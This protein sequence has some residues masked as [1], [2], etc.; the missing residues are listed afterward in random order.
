VHPGQD[1]FFLMVTKDQLLV[2]LKE[3]RKTW[4]SGELL[5][6]EL[7]V[8]RSAVWKHIRKL[9]EEG[10]VIESSPKKGYLLRRD[11]D[12]LL[13]NE[14]RQGL[15]TEVFGK[16]GIEYFKEID[17]TNTKAKDLAQRGAPEGTVVIAEKQTNGRGRRGRTWLSP[18]GD[19]I[20][21]TLIL[22][23]AMS[24]G[25]APKIT[26][27]T[28]VAIAEALLSLVPIDI[29]IKWPN[30]ILV[31]GRK[32]AGILT[33]I[34]ADMDAVN[35]IVVGLGLN[36]NTR[37]ESFS[38]EIGKI[39]T[40]IYIET[41]KHLSRAGLIRAYLEQ[42]EKYYKMFTQNEFAAIMGRWKQLSGFI[43]QKVMVDVIG[44]NYIGEVSDIDDDGVLI[45]K[46][47]QGRSRR[48]FSGDV[49]PVNP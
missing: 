45:L 13:P 25:G 17:S 11:S 1:V 8:S 7:S 38:E 31:N 32:L 24:P 27:M 22:R 14:I 43:G 49:I 36:V 4:I 41:G 34:T 10:Y 35:Y 28:A 46:D 33:E 37:S 47:D 19:G 44:R 6:D 23:P 18:E 39:A 30:D 12:L 20:Y 3:K 2:Y 42:F 21:A 9:R 26:L 16:K 48:I 40:S 5:S 15:N 29:R